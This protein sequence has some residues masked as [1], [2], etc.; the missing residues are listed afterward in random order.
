MTNEQYLIVSYF[1]AGGSGVVLA[2]V[3]GLVLRG[4]LRSAV[5]RFSAP[6]QRLMGRTLFAWL[7]MGALLAFMSVGYFGDCSHHTYKS[8]VEDLPW[9]VGKTRQQAQNIFG[10]LLAGVLT[11]ATAL[12]IVLGLWRPA[13]D[14]ES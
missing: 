5:A 7:L 12:A 11:Y 13:A 8:I 3:T 4:P 6:A 14:T 9:M 1:T 2:C 10:C